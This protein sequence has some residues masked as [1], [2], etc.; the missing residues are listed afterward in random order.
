MRW[1][2]FLY[3]LPG[4]SAAEITKISADQKDSGEQNPDKEVFFRKK[5]CEKNTE[6]DPEQ[7][8]PYRFFHNCFTVLSFILNI[9]RK[10]EK[11]KILFLFYSY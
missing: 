5:Q 8:K 7:D 2:R 10:N 11:S 9:C 6:S 1:L 4:C 3:P